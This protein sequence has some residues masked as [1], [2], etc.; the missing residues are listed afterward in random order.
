[1]AHA[2]YKSLQLG[3]LHFLCDGSISQQA[4][5]DGKAGVEGIQAGADLHFLYLVHGIPVSDDNPHI[6][7]RGPAVGKF[8][9]N[10]QILGFFCIY[11]RRGI[12]V[13]GGDEGADILQA[14]CNQLLLHHGMG[15][16]GDL[17]DHAPGEG[18]TLLI[19]DIRFKLCRD[20]SFFPPRLHNG[21]NAA[22]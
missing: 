4:A 11:K 20:Q 6:L 3:I 10:Y 13:F 19:A 21:K 15:T 5:V 16:G 17:V 14:V 12:G 7:Q 1:M 22:S 9:L 18:N 8:V 2:V